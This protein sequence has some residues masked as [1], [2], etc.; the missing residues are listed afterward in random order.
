MINLNNRIEAFARLSNLISQNKYKLAKIGI[1]PWFTEDNIIYA[2]DAWVSQ[3]Q[4]EK[5]NAWCE[6]YPQLNQPQ[7]PKRIAVITAGNLPLV[8]F[9]DFLSVLIAG[10]HFVGKLSSKNNKLLPE[11]A[12]LLIETEPEFANHIS[13]P[14]ENLS[15]FD[16]VIATGSNNSARYFD[17]YFG[18]YP[19]I[20]RKNRNSIAVLSGNETDTQLKALADD[21]FLYFGL[22]CRNVSK[23]FVPKDF[24][25]NRIFANVL[26]KQNVINHNK[27]ANNYDY[28]RAIY[29]MN[30]E[31]FLDNGFLMLK[32]SQAISSPISV[33]FYERY[34]DFSTVKNFITLNADKLQCVVA[35][36]STIPNSVDFGNTQNPT[37]QDYADGI[38]TLNFLLNLK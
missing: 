19:N 16:A 21:I 35:Q 30:Q 12:K 27:Y 33:V 2:I 6:K 25:L 7:S 15:N 32:E 22:G 20:I 11:I 3:L 9:H 17:Y 23:I 34:D 14:K 28:N 1:S 8:E 4:E 37:L 38:D 29:L 31:E 24:D 10:H 36:S 26:H 5:L 13:F 18:K